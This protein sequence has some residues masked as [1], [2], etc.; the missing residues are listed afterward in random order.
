VGAMGS[1]YLGSADWARALKAMTVSAALV[2]IARVLVPRGRRIASAT[3]PSTSQKIG[4]GY[5]CA[6]WFSRCCSWSFPARWGN[7]VASVFRSWMIWVKR[8]FCLGLR[9]T[10]S[11]VVGEVQTSRMLWS[12]RE[13]QT[14]SPPGIS[15]P[16]LGAGRLS[17]VGVGGVGELLPDRV[18]DT[19]DVG[20]LVRVDPFPCRIAER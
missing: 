2:S 10:N 18:G 17:S 5:Q 19:G 8:A 20:G 13:I 6:S 9:K 11:C 3:S 14:V 1:M 7:L 16:L 15:P 12:G 4:G